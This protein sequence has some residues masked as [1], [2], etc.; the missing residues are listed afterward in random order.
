ML[1]HSLNSGH[2]W[3]AP[4]YIRDSPDWWSYNDTNKNQP[5]NNKRVGWWHLKYM[6]QKES[7]QLRDLPEDDQLT[8][9]KEP[10]IR[11]CWVKPTYMCPT[12]WS[13]L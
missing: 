13:E 3:M 4:I 10:H 2:M 6:L 7:I 1:L 5:S 12:S 9:C 11:A 8:Q